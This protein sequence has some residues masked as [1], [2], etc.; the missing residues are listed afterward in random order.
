MSER[1]SV[2]ELL[3]RIARVLAEP[4]DDPIGRVRLDILRRIE[5]A[6]RTDGYP[7]QDQDQLAL[8]LIPFVFQEANYDGIDWWSRDDARHY[9]LKDMLEID[10]LTQMAGKRRS[11]ASDTAME[12]YRLRS[13]RA[14]DFRQGRVS[15]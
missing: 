13:H 14:I 2:V 1:V 15:S 4:S 11:D 3:E 7:T 9:Q 8:S 12:T 5:A 10:F 6:L